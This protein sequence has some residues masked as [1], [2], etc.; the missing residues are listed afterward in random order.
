MGW[1]IFLIGTI[2][3]HIGMYGMFKKAG[4]TPWKALIP[5]YN[6]WCIIEKIQ[7]RRVWFWLQFIPIAGQFISIWLTIIFVMHFGRF[8]VLHHA[9]AVLVPFVYFPYL[10]FSPN[11]RY[12]GH[13][14]FHNYKKPSSR[15]WVDAA[16][17]AV[18]AAT[19]IRTFI[20]EAYTIPTPS[21]EKTLLVNDFLF[22]NK[23]SYGPRI[24]KTPLS[25]PFVHNL[26]P[27]SQVPSYLKW[28]QIPY[29]RIPGYEKVERNDVVVFNFPL[30][31]TI[32]NDPG[33]GSA[34]PYYDVLRST[35][36]GNRN[37]LL[38]DWGDKIIVHPMDKADN[39]I[40]R[41]VAVAGDTLYLKNGELYV[42]NTKAYEPA[43]MQNDYNVSVKSAIDFNSLEE[44]ADIH[45]RWTDK[46]TEI[47]NLENQFVSSR[48]YQLSM[49]PEDAA[50]MKKMSNV[51]A[52]N[53]RLLPRIYLV[54]KKTSP[55]IYEAIHPS[56]FTGEAMKVNLNGY[57]RDMRLP[58]LD[59]ARFDLIYATK[60]AADAVR[61]S[62]NVAQVSQHD[63][64]YIF[65][66][67][68]NA[69]FDWT[70]DDFGPIIIPAKGTTISLTT[71][72]LPLYERII[73][74][75]EEHSL[76][77]KGNQ[78]IIDGK[79]ADKYTFKYN[80]YWMM[81]DNRHNSQDSRFWGFVPETH[82]VGKASFI[83]FSWEKG[84]RW[85]RIFSSIK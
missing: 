57:Q 11:E 78:I 59:T 15:E 69:G 29:S 85:K 24:P 6:T 82:V 75:Y 72:N 73:R 3:W 42:N 48:E 83:W 13:E 63:D 51:T 35:Y 81:G 67:I 33:Y 60:Q 49:S 64:A 37:A 39:Y 62:P 32:I 58:E 68:N 43:G 76:E 1:I 10:G 52:V 79:P 71:Q 27:N 36:G 65:P 19:L 18:V 74:N 70:V 45:I 44:N 17:F 66:N 53:I 54:E 55:V 40:K 41:C 8:N 77:V 21:M 34:K 30:G 28:I 5:F 25:F 20:F 9:G 84:P 16:V 61:K 31:D 56:F 23:V 26:M 12:A 80:Y 22:V 4:I 14:V 7:V 2:G 47:A 50:K 38:A 46:E